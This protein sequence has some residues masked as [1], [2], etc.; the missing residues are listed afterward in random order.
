MEFIKKIQCGPILKNIRTLTDISAK[1]QKTYVKLLRRVATIGALQYAFERERCSPIC[2]HGGIDAAPSLSVDNLDNLEDY[3]TLPNTGTFTVK[4]STLHQFSMSL[5]KLFY[6]LTREES[7]LF[8]PHQCFSL[9]FNVQHFTVPP[10]NLPVPSSADR[11]SVNEH[12]LPSSCLSREGIESFLQSG[13]RSTPSSPPS[14]P[15]LKSGPPA[16]DLEGTWAQLRT[17]IDHIMKRPE[18]GLSGVRLMEL[19]SYCLSGSG[20][21]NSDNGDNAEP[22]SLTIISSENIAPPIPDN[23]SPSQLSTSTAS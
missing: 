2:L 19:F 22:Q 6:A 9:C 23:F 20:E 7:H 21:A 3:T 1:T 10:A 5:I 12:F 18:E 8:W 17:S 13:T 4:K 11:E 15:F 14:F 16:L